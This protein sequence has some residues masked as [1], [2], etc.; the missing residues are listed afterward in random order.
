MTRIFYFMATN[1]AVMA[2]LSVVLWLASS[3]FGINLGSGYTSLLV[4]SLVIGM[5]G[6]VIS[7]FMSK[8]AAI[9]G[10]GVRIIENPATEEERWLVE[11]VHRQAERMGIGNPD[12]GV[13]DG[14]ELNA[15]ATGAN[16]NDALVAVS[17]GLLRGMDKREVEAVLG[18][19]VA[20]VANGDMITLTL[21]Q[22]VVN[23]F[24]FFFAR[25]IA[26]AVARDSRGGYFITSMIAQA[27]L[28]VLATMIVM[29]F[30]RRREF[31]ADEGGAEL[32]DTGAMA[33]ALARLK[34]NAA[35]PPMPD[36]LRA[37]GISGGM[38]AGFKRLFSS[39]PP[40]DE[41]IARLKQAS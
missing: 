40:I 16:R 5:A 34:A 20:H 31:R 36:E 24:V 41:R 9:R 8:R 10:M 28:G 32:T 25:V 27:V 15:F 18:H 14:P 39:H 13:Y 30:S 17:S 2:V 11:T 35:A 23:T 38:S 21:I 26:Q 22:G 7:L 1:I 3:L 33:G 6:S 19:E 29:Y 4:M 37:F 12:V